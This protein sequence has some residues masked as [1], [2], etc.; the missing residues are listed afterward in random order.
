MNVPLPAVLAIDGPAGSGK[1]TVAKALAR[2]LGLAY[3]DT[4]AMYRAVTASVLRAGLDPHGEGVAALAR[5]CELELSADRVLVDGA[6]VTEQIRG[7]EVTAAVSAVS[8]NAE[9]RA[10][11]VTRQRNWIL[12]QG[13][14]VVEGRDIGTVVA[15]EA[16]L[17]V[18]LTASAEAR[19]S[20]RVAEG[21]V[22]GD[23]AGVAA[24]LARRDVADATRATAPLS[25]AA[26]AVVVDTTHLGI[27]QVVEQLATLWCQRGGLAPSTVRTP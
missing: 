9:V 10:E 19:A 17:K 26:D 21:T 1:S 16:R 13:P 6:D 7:P 2:R 14:S 3:L 4:G 8:A 20:R 27:E 12:Q 5:R 11:L 23:Q 22:G 25:V 18:H 15:P 24:A